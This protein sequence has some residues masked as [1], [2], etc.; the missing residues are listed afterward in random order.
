MIKKG[1]WHKHVNERILQS[2]MNLRCL[3]VGY[4]GACFQLLTQEKRVE[5]RGHMGAGM[6]EVQVEGQ[7]HKQN[8]AKTLQAA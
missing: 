4:E 8:H 1:M 2:N 3:A 5:A 6:R 7:Q